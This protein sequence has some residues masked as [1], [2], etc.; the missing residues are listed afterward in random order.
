MGGAHVHVLDLACRAQADG[1]EVEVL[2]GGDGPYSSLLRSKGLQV[3]NLRWLIRPIRPHIDALAVLEVWQALKS[4]APD[5]VHTHSTKA[6]LV[7]RMAAWFAGIPAIFTAHG[8]AFTEGV[9]ERS[10]RLARFLERHAARISAA[11]ICVSE[12]DRKLAIDLGVGNKDILIK[13]HN[14]V[15]NIPADLCANHAGGGYVKI[16]SVARL[17]APKDHALLIDALA[18]INDMA[19]QLELI[20]DGPLTESIR[21]R[22]RA[23]GLG[24][25]VRFSGLCN[26]VPKR[27]SKA[28]LSVLTSSF[29]GF[30]LSILE[31][32]RASLP[33]IASNVGGVPESVVDGTTGFL[34]PKGDK[35]ALVDRLRRLLGDAQLRVQMGLAGRAFYEREFSFEVMYQRTLAVYRQVLRLKGRV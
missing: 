17:D 35:E 22:A 13:I 2:V 14:G 6:G 30:P 25:R 5:V 18:T 29:E 1:H 21:A 33:V 28:D 11:I 20:G 24:E 10:R 27:L 16:V 34:V 15:L 3:V 31:A 23:Y 32:M 4:F 9:A 8:W 19:W 7:G 26:D 12:Y